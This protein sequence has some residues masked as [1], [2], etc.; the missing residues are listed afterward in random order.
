MLVNMQSVPIVVQESA[1]E[2]PVYS[3]ANH[4]MLLG[5]PLKQAKQIVHGVPLGNRVQ[6]IEKVVSIVQ[7]GSSDLQKQAQ[8]HVQIAQMENTKAVLVL[9]H[10]QQ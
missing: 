3:A 5:T 6:Q 4:V 2:L 10:V 1:K 8:M 9:R 7:Q